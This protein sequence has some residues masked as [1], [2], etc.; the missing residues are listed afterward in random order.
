MLYAG[1]Q[2]DAHGSRTHARVLL[3]KAP[4]PVLTAV[5]TAADGRPPISHLSLVIQKHSFRH[6]RGWANDAEAAG[7]ILLMSQ[8]VHLSL[9]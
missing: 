6:P 4:A 1:T 7:G 2:A 9:S 8:P 3:A 5:L